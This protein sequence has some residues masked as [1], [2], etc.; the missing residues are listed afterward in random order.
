MS[1]RGRRRAPAVIEYLYGA[2]HYW[3][4]PRTAWPASRIIAFRIVRKTPKR[5]HYIRHQDGAAVS[6]GSADRHAIETIGVTPG[7]PA[8]PGDPDRWLYAT[9]AHAETAT[10]SGPPPPPGGDLRELRRD[11]AAA[12]PDRGGTPETFQDAAQRYQAALRTERNRPGRT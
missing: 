5:I 11:M 8:R 9:R 2:E 7:H 3:P 6:Y 10:G 4:E 1:T 12:H